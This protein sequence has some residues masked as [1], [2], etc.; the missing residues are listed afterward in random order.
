MSGLSLL[1][2]SSS[3]VERWSFSRVRITLQRGRLVG[4]LLLVVFW[5]RVV[6]GLVFVYEDARGNLGLIVLDRARGVAGLGGLQASRCLR[7][8]ELILFEWLALLRLLVLPLA[9]RSMLALSLVRNAFVL[10]DHL[11]ILEQTG[12][13]VGD[14]G[15]L[16][17]FVL[18]LGVRRERLVLV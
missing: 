3:A 10:R 11:D 2:V 7:L 18:A 17:L 14:R 16:L 1:E 5:A 4:K 12:V 15:E 6:G 13:V 8:A 9:A